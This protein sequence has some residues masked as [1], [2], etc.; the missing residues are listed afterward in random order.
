MSNEPRDAAGDASVDD[1]LEHDPTGHSMVEVEDLDGLPPPVSAL[2]PM[3]QIAHLGH[4]ARSAKRQGRLTT[5]FSI[6]AIALAGVVG[7]VS[8]FLVFDRLAGPG[9][10]RIAGIVAIVVLVVGL[11]VGIRRPR[12]VRARRVRSPARR[13]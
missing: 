8:M 4:L 6:A 13:E 12:E 5:V 2:D 7:P 11:L 9:A 1:L 10:A 3:G